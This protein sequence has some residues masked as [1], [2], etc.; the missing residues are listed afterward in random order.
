MNRE[1]GDLCNLEDLLMHPSC[2]LVINGMD[3]GLPRHKVAMVTSYA[4]S[5]VVEYLSSEGCV[6]RS[7]LQ[8]SSA[9][10]MMSLL[11]TFFSSKT[12]VSHLSNVE[13]DHVTSLLLQVRERA[14]KV[15][16]ARENIS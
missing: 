4:L 13:L 9:G 14:V 2:S 7:D 11:R 10:Q 15:N 6:C 16:Y 1:R 3:L 12:A 8:L 5:L